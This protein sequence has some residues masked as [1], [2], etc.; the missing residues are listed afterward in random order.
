MRQR[1]DRGFSLY[2]DLIRLTAAL[3]VMFSHAQ[4]SGLINLHTNALLDLA[5]S[6]VIVFFVLSGYIIDATTDEAAG[7]RRYALH[8]T[9]RIYSVV[10]LAVLLSIA[11]AGGY[12]A[13][14]DPGGFQSFNRDWLQWWRLPVV[15]SFQGEDWFQEVQVPWNGPFWSLH[16][17]VFYYALYAALTFTAGRR[18][19]LLT[20]AVCLAAGPKILLL[21][22]CWW[23]GVEIARR[24]ELRFPS[25]CL[26]WAAL[27][28][29]PVLVVG[30]ALSHLPWWVKRHLAAIEPWLWKFGHSGLFVTDYMAALLVGAG[31]IAAR[32]LSFGPNSLLVRSGKPI[33]WAAGMT[34][35]I[36]LFHR[37]LQHLVSHYFQIASGTVLQAIL[38][39]AAIVLAIGGLAAI[40]ER[41]TAEWRRMLGR[42][43]EPG[44][45]R[46]DGSQLV[47]NE[48]TR[49]SAT[50]TR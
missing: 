32:Q 31:F 36:Y 18:R 14:S 12:A 17:E 21:L 19:V 40:S 16:Y 8:R 11:L 42:F 35:S 20:T 41:R 2:L 25:R 46:T 9:A 7:F 39:Q 50:V 30:I 3:I 28:G 43:I 24:P 45:G 5:P 34:F 29:S 23:L 44:K 15:L 26:A 33:A 10:I 47:E 38:V 13:L 6:A 49:A 22:P 27:L 37:P 48:D 4:I 1:I